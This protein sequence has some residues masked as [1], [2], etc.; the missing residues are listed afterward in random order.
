MRTSLCGHILE[1]PLCGPLCGT[2]LGLC[3]GL[4]RDHS[5]GLTTLAVE[6]EIPSNPQDRM[7]AAA[8][9]G[10]HHRG[11]AGNDL[12]GGL[13]EESNVFGAASGYNREQQLFTLWVTSLH[14]DAR[15]RPLATRAGRARRA[16]VLECPFGPWCLAVGERTIW[17]AATSGTAPESGGPPHLGASKTEVYGCTP[18]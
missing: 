14:S 11:A 18:P 3:G 9:Q 8:V 15:R 4:V 7:A 5:L 12:L 13:L 2:T 6:T 17:V 1:R 16:F 10:K